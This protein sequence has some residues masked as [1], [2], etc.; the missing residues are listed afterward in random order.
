MENKLTG[1]PNNGIDCNSFQEEYDSLEKLSPDQKSHLNIC[2]DCSLWQTEVDELT[3]M[4]QA[5][6]QFDVG[7]NLTQKILSGVDGIE[8]ERKSKLNSV[9][10]F[11]LFGFFI[12]LLFFQDSLESIW[13]LASWLLGFGIIAGLKLLISDGSGTDK[14]QPAN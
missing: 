1:E 13:G 8:L 6:P 3:V 14:I 4:A 7:E 2:Q 11:C 10:T 9:V 5:A 12:W